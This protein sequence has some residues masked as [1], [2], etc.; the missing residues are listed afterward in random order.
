MATELMPNA[1]EAENADAEYMR[2]LD[3]LVD[4]RNISYDQAMQILGDTPYELYGEMQPDDV[5]E[6]PKTTHSES[7][8]KRRGTAHIGP[9][10]GQDE[11]YLDGGE[12]VGPDYYRPYKPLNAAEAAER[13]TTA[14]NGAA[15]ARRALRGD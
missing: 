15:L 11:G 5:D 13:A 2:R 4:Q 12:L 8:N 10:Y 1:T 7:G 3:E 9:Q 6:R 14:R